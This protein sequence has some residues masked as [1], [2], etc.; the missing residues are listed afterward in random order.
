MGK[1]NCQNEEKRQLNANTNRK[2][3]TRTTK[4]IKVLFSNCDTLT[5]KLPELLAYVDS[6]QPLI[7]GLNEVKPKHYTRDL[8]I[9]EFKLKDYEIMPHPNITNKQSERGTILHIHNSLPAKQISIDVNGEYFEEV[10][11][12]EICLG[13]SDICL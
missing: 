2:T 6:F 4:D 5:N 11:F 1:K 10:V 7:I 13:E 3:K 8:T 9:E 12:S